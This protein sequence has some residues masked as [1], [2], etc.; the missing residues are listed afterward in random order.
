MYKGQRTDSLEMVRGMV[1]NGHWYSVLNQKL[2]TP[3]SYDGGQLV[4]K[5]LTDKLPALNVVLLFLR[6]T[7]LTRRTQAVITFCQAFYCGQ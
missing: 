5:P 7:R 6:E 3:I 4:M 2:A 1:A